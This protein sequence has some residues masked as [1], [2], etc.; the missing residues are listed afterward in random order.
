MNSENTHK[1]A[2]LTVRDLVIAFSA[3][4][5]LGDVEED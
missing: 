1:V 3:I 5:F 2:V 4:R